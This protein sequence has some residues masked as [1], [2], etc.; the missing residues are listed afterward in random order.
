M[1]RR[2]TDE[3]IG[4]AIGVLAEKVKLEMDFELKV[5]KSEMMYAE[6]E[7]FLSLNEEQKKLF[8]IYRKRKEIFFD[9]AEQMYKRKI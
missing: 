6:N 9:I 8:D 7:L 4:K 3:E 2:L 5:A 1:E